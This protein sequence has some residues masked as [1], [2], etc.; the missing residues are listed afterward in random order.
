MQALQDQADWERRA[1]GAKELLNDMV[2]SRRDAAQL[3]Q[4]YDIKCAPAAVPL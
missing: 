4:Q 2:R 3:S 1:R